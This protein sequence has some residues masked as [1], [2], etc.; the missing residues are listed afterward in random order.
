MLI[1]VNGLVIRSYPSGNHDR[2]IHILTEDR[3]RISVMVK[4]GSSPKTS[5]AQACT[6]L[7]TYGN[8]ELY[9]GKGGDLYWFRGGSVISSFFDLTA[10]LSGTALAAY[11]CDVASELTVEDMQDAEDSRELLRMLLNS[12]HVMLHGLKPLP[13]VKAVFELR[14]AAIMGYMPDL[15][16]CD[17]CGEVYPENA[18]LDI[19]DGRIVCADCRAKKISLQ[20]LAR[21]WQEQDGRKRPICPLSSSVLMAMRYILTSS[22]KKLF[23]FAMKDQEEEIS[24]GRATEGF[25]LHHLERDFDTLH[26]Y[27]NL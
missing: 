23:S 24:L 19:P 6:Q 17:M 18:Y 10:D 11:L 9:D 2:V 25:L 22:P 1:T 15:T 20:D 27:K 5:A 16:G 7:F 13:L 21:E 4:G 3:G 8:Y 26:F 14:A 12:L